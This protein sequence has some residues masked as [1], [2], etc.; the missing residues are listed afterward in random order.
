MALW[1]RRRFATLEPGLTWEVLS[2]TGSQMQ[3]GVTTRGCPTGPAHTSLQPS[4]P[5][6][7]QV[8]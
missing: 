3:S 6:H 2:H 5:P 8:R 7:L 1:R 4:P